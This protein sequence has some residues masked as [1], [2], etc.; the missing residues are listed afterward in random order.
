MNTTKEKILEKAKKL[1]AKKGYEA[2]SMSEVAKATNIE[3][4]SLYYFFKNKESLFIEILE[5]IWKELIHDVYDLTKRRKEYKSNQEHFAAIIEH[6]INRSLEGGIMLGMSDD[7]CTHMSKPA[8]FKNI[9]KHIECSKKLLREGLKKYG[10]K[11]S[12]IAEELIGNACHAYIVHKQYCKKGSEVKKY[13]NY[14]SSILI[15]N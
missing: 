11:Q 2:T 15:K 8:V 14:L 5:S 10:V 7:I 6:F 13:A 1:F 3:K 4:S 9:S 12:E